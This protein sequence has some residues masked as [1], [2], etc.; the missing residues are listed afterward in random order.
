M[1]KFMQRRTAKRIANQMNAI[2]A[3]RAAG[4]RP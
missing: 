3:W 4:D 1:S 2:Y